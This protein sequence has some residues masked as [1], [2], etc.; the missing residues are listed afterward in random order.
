[1][2]LHIQAVEDYDRETLRTLLIDAADELVG[3]GSSV[4]EPMLPWDGHPILL[5]DAECRPV[6]VSFDRDNSQAALL[7]GLR[8]SDQLTLA[9]PWVNQVYAALKQQQQPPRLIVVSAEP[10]P[11]NRA[12][13]TDSQTITLL[14][15]RV[16]RVN[17]DT[18]VLLEQVDRE[19]RPAEVATATPRQPQLVPVALAS[20]APEP[21]ADQDLAPLSEQ[22]TAYF[23]QL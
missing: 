12:V 20:R 13:L 8:A 19:P 5:V 11:G 16:L 7:S 23:Q 6:L 14:T 9:L 4:L 17:E 3:P 10:P 1:M 2:K 21:T 15:C 18:G 22:E